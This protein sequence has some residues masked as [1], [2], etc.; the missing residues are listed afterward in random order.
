MLAACMAAMT[1][2]RVKSDCFS[3]SPNKNSAYCSKRE[4]LPPLGFAITLPERVD[5]P[6]HLTAELTLTPK[7]SA[8]L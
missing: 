8:A 6:I 4:V 3:M 1:S 2:S 5:C 7:R